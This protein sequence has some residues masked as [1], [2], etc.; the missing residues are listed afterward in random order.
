MAKLDRNRSYATI[1]PR[2]GVVAF[3]QD[4]KEFDIHG[5]EL[6]PSTPATTWR[7]PAPAKVETVPQAAE[8]DPVTPDSDDQADE[9]PD[10]DNMRWS[11]LKVI[12]LKTFGGRIPKANVAR[13]KLN[14]Y[15]F[16]DESG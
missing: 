3:E 8:S 9:I 10:F 12:Y 4:G 11:E 13:E 14:A 5:D 16:G 7:R 2:G 1:T 15:F 6:L